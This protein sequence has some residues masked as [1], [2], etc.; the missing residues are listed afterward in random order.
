[1]DLRIIGKNALV[2]GGSR[3]IGRA[4]SL[5][6]G[7]EGCNVGVVARSQGPLDEVVGMIRTAGGSA[8]AVTGDVTHA[9]TYEDLL[10]RYRQAFGAPDIVVFSPPSPV[11]GPILPQD[12]TGL[13]QTYNDLVLCFLK[14]AQ[15][16]IPEMRAKKWGRFVTVGSASIQSPRV[17]Q[18]GVGFHYALGNINRMA[19]MRLSK[20]IAYE[21][22][23]DGITLNTIGV[24]SF[25]T[26][27]FDEHWGSLAR[28]QGKTLDEMTAEQIEKIPIGRLGTVEEMAQLCAFLCSDGAGYTT[29]ETI[30]CDGGKFVAAL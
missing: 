1:M 25:K 18:A 7:L 21:V 9:E 23:G 26:E 20:Q 11:A 16:T 3:G 29:G 10:G 28:A 17:N 4:I 22:A 2:L 8:A 12:E 24:G 30:L 27:T 14:I 5:R 6:L 13:V 15:L 19:A